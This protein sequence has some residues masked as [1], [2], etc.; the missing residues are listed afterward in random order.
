MVLDNGTPKGMRQVL[1]D[2]HINVKG[3]VA[4]DMQNVLGEM[5]DFK[6][7]KTKVEKYILGQKH[8]VLFIPKFH[9]ELNPIQRCWGAAKQYTR[10]HCDYPFIWIREN[11]YSSS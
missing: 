7:E 8:R 10:Q 6:Y 9:C 2:R 11:N 5:W 1:I 3:M 4:A